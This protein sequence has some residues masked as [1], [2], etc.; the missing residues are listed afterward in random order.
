MRKKRK[1][2]EAKKKE[3]DAA[4]KREEDLMQ[5]LEEKGTSGRLELMKESGVKRGWHGI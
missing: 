4:A 3:E 1:E 2:E 5:W